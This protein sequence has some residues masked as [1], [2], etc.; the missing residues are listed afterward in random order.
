MAPRYGVGATVVVKETGLVGTVVEVRRVD[1]VEG[2]R[3]GGR[4]VYYVRLDDGTE[5]SIYGGSRLRCAP[6]AQ[7]QVNCRW[8]GECIAWLE[9]SAPCSGCARAFSGHPDRFRPRGPVPVAR[10]VAE[11]R[12]C[13][14]GKE[15]AHEGGH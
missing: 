6:R 8:R 14:K 11:P 5:V 2:R 4:Y 13:C 7:A 15:D 1:W 10:E 9:E 3:A 12:D